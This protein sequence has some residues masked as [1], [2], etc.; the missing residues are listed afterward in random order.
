MVIFTL[1]QAMK[2]NSGSKCFFCTLLFTS[3]LDRVCG[4]RNALAALALQ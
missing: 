1:R 4:Q 2:T 3:A